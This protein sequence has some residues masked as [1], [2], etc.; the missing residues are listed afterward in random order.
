MDEPSG[1]QSYPR[2]SPVDAMIFALLMRTPL[3]SLF[4]IAAVPTAPDNRGSVSGQVVLV[5]GGTPRAD[6]SNAAVWI[7]GAHRP[8]G[9]SP[10]PAATPTAV[11]QMRSDQK[12]F[13]PR[14]VVVSKNASVDF[15]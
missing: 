9:S 10:A 6:A 15:P 7:E 4:L 11:P 13:Q 3:L 14:V 8:L 1:R 2:R 5:A 12:R